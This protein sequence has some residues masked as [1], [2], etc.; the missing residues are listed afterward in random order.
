MQVRQAQVLGHQLPDPVEVRGCSGRG[1]T[2]G[3]NAL[4]GM[5]TLSW[6]GAVA[7]RCAMAGWGIMAGGAITGWRAGSRCSRARRPKGRLMPRPATPLLLSDFADSALFPN[8]SGSTHACLPTPFAP[9]LP[10]SG[11]LPA[12][13]LRHFH[14]R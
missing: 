6:S 3:R 8:L 7:C 11:L 10:S 1:V 2:P 4:A 13:R 5:G 9:G 12:G 14:A